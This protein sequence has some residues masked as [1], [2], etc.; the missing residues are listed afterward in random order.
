[1]HIPHR[2]INRFTI[3]RTKDSLGFRVLAVVLVL[4]TMGALVPLT[5][6]DGPA[7]TLGTLG[8]IVAL[9]TAAVLL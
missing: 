4:T 6:V 1:M 5:T 3:A 8:L 2:T 7:A 9:A